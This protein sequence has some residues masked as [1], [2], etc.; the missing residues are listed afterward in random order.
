MAH[1]GD[2]LT[3]LFHL[4][5]V[6]EEE[7]CRSKV[8]IILCPKSSAMSFHDRSGNGQ[9]DPNAVLLRRNKCVEYIVEVFNRYTAS[10]IDEFRE[11]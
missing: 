5:G 7:E 1:P 2:A 10:V 3:P 8:R 9:P 4:P 11:T 6:E